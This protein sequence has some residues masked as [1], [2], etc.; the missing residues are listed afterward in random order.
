M[1]VRNALFAAA[2]LLLS[3]PAFADLRGMIYE[4]ANPQAPYKEWQRKPLADAY[5]VISW[6]VSIPAPGHSPSYCKHIEI[7][8]SN[9]KGEYTLEGPGLSIGMLGHATLM[10]AYSPGLQRFDWPWAERPEALKEI[11]MVTLTKTADERLSQLGFF[12]EPGCSG[13]EM[14]DPKGVLPAYY[15]V[16][17]EEAKA[18][19]PTSQAATE[20]LRML[21]AKAKSPGPALVPAGAVPV[22]A[23]IEAAPDD[24]RQRR[25]KAAKQGE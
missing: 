19:K 3:Q 4:L 22:P 9:D 12:G 5:V 7:A 23:R 16:L 24:R 17:V 25:A 1:P 20:N 6:S 8:R 14:H 13:V 21:E 10:T 2:L 11:S 15:A 18:L